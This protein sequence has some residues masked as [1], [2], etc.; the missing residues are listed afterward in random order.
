MPSSI[1]I[2]NPEANIYWATRAKLVWTTEKGYPD[3]W[4]TSKKQEEQEEKAA[5]VQD[6]IDVKRKR[7]AASSHAKPSVEDPRA[8]KRPARMKIENNPSPSLQS[9]VKMEIPASAAAAGRD[10]FSASSS[11]ARQ[12]DLNEFTDILPA[13]G[14]SGKKW[15]LVIGN[16][17]YHD[18]DEH[19]V[20]PTHDADDFERL[21]V[22]TLKYPAASVTKKCN[23]T[24]EQ[25]K[26]SLASLIRK[27]ESGDLV[28]V[29]FAGHGCISKKTSQPHI[30]CCGPEKGTGRSKVRDSFAVEDIQKTITQHKDLFGFVLI[31]DACRVKASLGS[32]RPPP[33]EL[34]WSKSAGVPLHPHS[35]LV[36]ACAQHETASDGTGRNGTFTK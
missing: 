35:F 34:T 4:F 5:A 22:D 23:V 1:R 32:G 30:L 19:L 11:A 10:S 3:E 16:S 21:L 26:D 24:S 2:K 9:S 18:E 12:I 14:F 31:L 20:N 33:T 27:I 7:F 29:F 17:T 28:V 13:E 6:R 36:F 8:G 25:V 15:A